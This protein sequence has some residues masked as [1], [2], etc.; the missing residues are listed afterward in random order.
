MK[1]NKHSYLIVNEDNIKIVTSLKAAMDLQESAIL[2]L[3]FAGSMRP[4]T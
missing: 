4:E 1:R 3:R 2:N